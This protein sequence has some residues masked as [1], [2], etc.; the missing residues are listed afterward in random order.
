M[1]P[2]AELSVDSS[3]KSSS[4]EAS[5]S[6]H[7]RLDSFIDSQTEKMDKENK[8]NSNLRK[9]Y[10]EDF[11]LKKK[12]EFMPQ[13]AHRNFRKRS[14]DISNESQDDSESLKSMK[15]ELKGKARVGRFCNVEILM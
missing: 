11:H 4:S 3:F 8:G 2:S 13:T 14:A 15:S 1:Q 10:S 12:S 9:K 5:G 6:R 7:S